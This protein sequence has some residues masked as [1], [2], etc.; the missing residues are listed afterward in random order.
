M[1]RI[2]RR[3]LA[4]ASLLVVLATAACG[5][6]TQSSSSPGAA[7]ST[8]SAPALVVYSGRNENLVGPLLKMFTTET[9]IA[10]TPRYG[11]SAELAAQLLEEGERTPASV[12][13]SQD[14]GAL[15]ALQKAERL[16]VLDD[17][18]LAKV[19]SKFRSA[20][21]NW[22]GVSGR[23]RVLIYNTD[24]VKQAD[25]PTSVLE[26]TGPAYKG[27]VG[28]APTNA[29]FQAFVTGLRITAGE[30]KAKQFLTAFKA[31]DPK[32]YDKNGLI[33]D[34]VNKGEIPFGLVNHYYLYEKAAEAGGLEKFKA[35]NHFFSA[36]DPG[37]LV[38]VAG[39]GV[40]AGNADAR[41]QAFVDFLLGATAQN[42][43]ASKTYEYPL[44]PGVPIAAPGIPA[45]DPI[46]GPDV[47]LSQLDSLDATLAMLDQV[48]LT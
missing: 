40:L 14:A 17:A 35:R 27:K 9:G 29:S 44:I 4:A 34:A 2:A 13:L 32:A 25:L 19:P 47:D 10:V 26:L 43:F 15:G 30:A 22:V 1:I 23:A 24:L 20:T 42:Y 12:F 8:D 41:S 33:V 21:G 48:G 37:A 45:L 36:K 16:T 11:D 3:P 7:P 5:S 39:V 46:Q 6:G 31:N 18:Q 28:F 38:N